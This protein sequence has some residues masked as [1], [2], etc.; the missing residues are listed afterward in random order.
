LNPQKERLSI[1]PVFHFCPATKTERF[2]LSPPRRDGKYHRL[3]TIADN[4]NAKKLM[5]DAMKSKN[6]YRI[7]I[8]THMYADTFCHRDFAGWKDE[9]NEID[10]LPEI[11]AVGPAHAGAKP[12]LPTP[13]W[14]D[15]RLTSKHREKRN[16]EQILA[17][18]GNIF[19]FFYKNTKP[20][21]AADIK[22]KLVGDLGV[23]IGPEVKSLAEAEAGKEDGM[24]NYKTMLGGECK[25]Y[26]DSQ[27]ID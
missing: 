11:F 22:S 5:P 27:W 23:T 1:Y 7:G 3:N 24:E 19:D 6:F 20:A 25:K 17:A 2:R 10:H 13:I 26:N 12:D 15:P 16:K 9:F 14:E 21:N 8:C 18:A 4:R